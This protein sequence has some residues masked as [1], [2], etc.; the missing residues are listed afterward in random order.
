LDEQEAHK[1][2]R[3]VWNYVWLT[4]REWITLPGVQRR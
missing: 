2:I 4:M 1:F 3:F